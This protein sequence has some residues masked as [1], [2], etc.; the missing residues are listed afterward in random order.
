MLDTFLLAIPDFASFDVWIALLALTFLQ[1]VLGVDNIIF[2]IIAVKDLKEKKQPMVINVGLILAMVF[3]ILLL[4][5][6]S[7]L[8]A[9]QDPLWEIHLGWLNVALTGQSIIMFGGGLFLLYKS[10]SEID[11]KLEGESHVQ[12]QHSEKKKNK[13]NVTSI[14]IEIVIINIVFSFDSILTAVGMTDSLFIMIVSVVISVVIMMVF[15]VKIGRFM[16]N[17]P[18][19]QM[20]GLAFLLLVGFLLLAEGAHMSHLEIFGSTVGAIPKGYLYFAIGFALL[21]EFLNMRFRK[22]S[23]PVQLRGIQEEAEEEK[24]YEEDGS[25]DAA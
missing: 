4:I 22:R 11:S 17:N 12:K 7:Y 14:I 15:T 2:I 19:F 1:I 8:I 10:V 6:A 13:T 9:M 16:N 5:G 23:K 25:K 20:L 3:R 24:I 21:V 18:T